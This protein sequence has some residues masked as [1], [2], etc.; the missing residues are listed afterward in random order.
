MAVYG[1]GAYHGYDVSGDFKDN[2][3]VGTGWDYKTAP[4]LHAYFEILEPGDV[5]YLK[6][7]RPGEPVT[8]KG[9][10][11]IN[12][13]DIISGSYGDCDLDTGRKVKWLDKSVFQLKDHKGKNNVRSNTIY[14]ETHPE[15]INVIMAI[16]ERELKKI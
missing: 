14:R 6:A 9:I 4:D 12:G 2:D 15:V 5:V 1:I 8:V 10:G 11:L 16:V 13:S 3:V 7:K